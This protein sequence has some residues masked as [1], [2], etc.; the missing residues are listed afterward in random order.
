MEVDVNG[1]PPDP[2]WGGDPLRRLNESFFETL[3]AYLAEIEGREAA[4]ESTE[5]SDDENGE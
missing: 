4:G 1:F 2:G 3:Q 5:P